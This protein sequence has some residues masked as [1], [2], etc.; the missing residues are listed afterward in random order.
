MHNRLKRK[1]NIGGQVALHI[2]FKNLIKQGKGK[3][4]HRNC[5]FLCP[6]GHFE[7]GTYV[8]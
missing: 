4:G 8:I 6:V 7:G 2:I 3:R 5:A 1:K